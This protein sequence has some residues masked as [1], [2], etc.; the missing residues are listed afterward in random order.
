MLM[1]PPPACWLISPADGPGSVKPVAETAPVPHSGDAAD[2]PAIWVNPANPS[3]S[4]IFDTDKQ[5]GLAVYDLAGKE[6]QYL[7]TAT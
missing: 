1:M 2:D 3:A 6:L 5:G 7:P 4:R